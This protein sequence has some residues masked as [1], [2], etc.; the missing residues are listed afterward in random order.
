MYEIIKHAHFTAVIVWILSMIFAMISLK[1]GVSATKAKILRIFMTLG[2]MFTWILGIYLAY[3][4]VFYISGWLWVKLAF[5][6]AL[7]GLHG[8]IVGKLKAQK[9]FQSYKP[10]AI[11]FSM[12]IAIVAIALF[13]VIAKPF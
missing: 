7:S 6:F 5:V 9:S 10:V 11:M 13:L 1:G 8:S 12:T 2:I 4:S 3:S